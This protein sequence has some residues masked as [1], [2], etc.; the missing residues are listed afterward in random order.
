MDI[1]CYSRRQTTCSPKWRQSQP[2]AQFREEFVAGFLLHQRIAKN[3]LP[4]EHGSRSD[5]RVVVVSPTSCAE[6]RE[7]NLCFDVNVF[8]VELMCIVA[9]VKYVGLHSLISPG[10]YYS[11]LRSIHLGRPL[12]NH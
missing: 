12:S 10:E 4:A 1:Q 7:G 9:Q 11:T 2:D 5:D 6:R 3:A 8:H